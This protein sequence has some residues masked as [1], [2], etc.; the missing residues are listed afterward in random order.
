MSSTRAIVIAAAASAAA[1]AL[2]AWRRRRL[3]RTAKPP[4]QLRVCVIG[5]GPAGL[6]TLSAFRKLEQRGVRIP[7]LVCYEKQSDWGGMWNYTWRTGID[8]KGHAVHGSMYKYLW[9]NAPKE[10]LELAD[11]SFDEHFGRPIA[12]YPPR[13]VVL[14]YFD[15]RATKAD[16][17]RLI[18]FD[19]SVD[20]VEWDAA[21]GTFTVTTTATA[22]ASAADP[23][24]AF[25]TT[26]RVEQFD[27]VVCASGHYS[28]P[29]FPHFAGLEDFH[30]W[31]YP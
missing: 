23:R 31:G 2:L 25:D 19:T 22:V 21:S 5:A 8:E 10:C 27:Y 26:R 14:D 12:S 9:S 24:G 29:N 16:V 11:Y 3:R 7:E 13:P 1:A 20:S 4:E 6:A 17:R 30:G 18:Q 15:G 28:T